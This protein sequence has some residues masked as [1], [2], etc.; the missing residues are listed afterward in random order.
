MI[1]SEQIIRQLRLGEDS[2]WEFKEIIFS[3]NRVAG[4]RPDNLADEI[5]AFANA[6]G[7]N[8]VCGVQDDG[9][10]QSMSRQEMDF[11]EQTI[12]TI[13]I[14]KIK[15]KVSFNIF[16]REIGGEPVMVVEI[17]KS[18]AAHESPGGYY[19]RQGSSKRKLTPDEF[20][21]LSQQRSQ[22]RY[23]WFDQQ[24]VPNTGFA[25]LEEKLWRPL[26]SAR[27]AADPVAA[28]EKMGLLGADEQGVPR[29]TVAGLLLCTETPES[30]LP[31][32]C[33][34]AARYQGGDQASGQADS[35]LITGPINQQIREAVAFAVRN[36]TV[37]ARK[38]PARVNLPEY[39]V[40]A[41]FEAMVNAV[42][43]RDYSV[44]GS[45]IRLFIFDDRIEL[46][47]PG[48]LPNGMTVATMRDRQSTRNEVLARVLGLMPV[49]VSDS[50]SDTG[51]G[52]RQFFMERRGDG[53]PIIEQSTQALC[54]KLPRFEMIDD[55]E[56]RLTIPAASTESNPAVVSMT[57]SSEGKPMEGAKVL[58]LFPNKT[59]VTGASDADGEVQLKLHATHLPMTVFVAAHG[60]AAHL[61]QEWMPLERAL[62]LELKA[63]PGGGSIIFPE[64]TGSIPGLSGRLNPVLDTS[65]R[66]YLYAS[67]IAIN[68]GQQQPV[69]FFLGEPLELMDAHG[70]QKE[71]RIIEI[72]GRAALVE[73]RELP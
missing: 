19:R 30:W 1:E 53:V 60:F 24:T 38:D 23:I 3:G 35:Q 40:N 59:W 58:A 68:Q 6:G 15:P 63:L 45:R 70:C 8:L 61:E 71:V 36:M 52:D 49:E 11:L 72:V 28:L 64:A 55:A 54:G 7:G 21:R 18:S 22:A 56:L 12:N 5:A 73:Y 33:I 47:S 25:S 17:P 9:S 34:T 32:A 43:H 39:S 42:V 50:A 44:R 10:V 51:S 2:L 46:Y 16:R 4:P 27:S 37:E 29:A 14:D 41:I 65:D 67:N 62:T 13:C 26:L 66:T 48:A 69:T 31:G 20:L 57:V